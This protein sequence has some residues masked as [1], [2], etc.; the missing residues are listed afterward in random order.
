M[1]TITKRLNR[2]GQ[3]IAWQAKVRRQGFPTQSKTFDRKSDADAW[4][5]SLEGEMDRGAFIDRRPAEQM[6]LGDAIRHYLGTVAPP[7]KGGGRAA[8]SSLRHGK[9]PRSSPTM[10]TTSYSQP[11]AEC[12]VNR[13][14]C[15]GEPS[16]PP[17]LA[18]SRSASGPPTV[19]AA[20]M[21][22][23]CSPWSARLGCPASDPRH[24]L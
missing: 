2:D 11:L 21:R 19:S 4:A 20:D 6:T 7:H 23:T 5:R 17:R 15:S 1:A 16:R 14:R 9:L 3:L 24:C 22:S 18:R 8:G 13:L 12:G 10:I